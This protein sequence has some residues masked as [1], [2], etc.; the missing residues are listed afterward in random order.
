[1]SIT[2][3]LIAVALMLVATAAGC[4][5]ERRKALRELDRLDRER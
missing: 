2:S 1:M 4:W 3:T 5:L